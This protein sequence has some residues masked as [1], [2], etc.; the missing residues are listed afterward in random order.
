MV[1]RCF[2]VSNAVIAAW[3][4]IPFWQGDFSRKVLLRGDHLGILRMRG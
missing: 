2:V 4:S 3:F 1:S